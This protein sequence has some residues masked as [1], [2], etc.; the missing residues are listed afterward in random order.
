MATSI[1]LYVINVVFTSLSRSYK[2]KF[3]LSIIFVCVALIFF[4]SDVYSHWKYFDEKNINI[5]CEQIPPIVISE[6]KFYYRYIAYLK[7]IYPEGINVTDFHMNFQTSLSIDNYEFHIDDTSTGSLIVDTKEASI[8]SIKIDRLNGKQIFAMTI[9]CSLPREGFLLANRA[10]TV[11]IAYKIFGKAHNKSIFVNPMKVMPL[12][13]PSKEAII[14]D[15]L[16]FLDH[17]KLPKEFFSYHYFKKDVGPGD[18]I[19]EVYCSDNKAR[20]LNVKYKNPRGVIIYVS[21]CPVHNEFDPIRIILFK[22]DH[23]TI[24]SK[25][26]SFGKIR[27]REAA[28]QFRLGLKLVQKRDYEGGAK[29]FKKVADVDPKDYQAWFNYGLALE[30]LKDIES[31]IAAFGKVIELNDDYAKAHY[32]LGNV[33]IKSGKNEE[34]IIHLKRAIGITPKYALAY[35]RLGCLQ[36]SYGNDEEALSNIK[37]A[38]EFETKAE[39]KDKYRRC[40][41]E[42]Q[43][44]EFQEI[45]AFSETF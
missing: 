7:N 45:Q 5:T 3:S 13:M 39:R 26:Q 9:D 10:A 33:L 30:H 29:A 2:I 20:F 16:R 28:M 22:N 36:K 6:N 11:N 42:L 32:E 37:K 43:S 38:I 35:F 21:E 4:L 44:T 12:Q 25:L 27:Q 23:M 14:L 8:L 34:A 31:A 40:L 24:Q 41:D 1:A 15:L 17:R 19:L 18:R